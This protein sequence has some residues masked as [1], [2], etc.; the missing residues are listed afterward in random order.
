MKNRSRTRFHDRH[1]L[2]GLFERG[3]VQAEDVVRADANLR[4]RA[5]EREGRHGDSVG[6]GLRGVLRRGEHVVADNAVQGE[7]VPALHADSVEVG[8]S[9]RLDFLVLQKAVALHSPTVEPGLEDGQLGNERRVGGPRP[10][11]AF[12][13]AVVPLPRAVLVGDFGGGCESG[14]KKCRRRQNS[15]SD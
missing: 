12:P 15:R 3:R 6:G 2:V 8:E 14:H 1:A 4:L 13:R 10:C 11:A 9:Q 5:L 7:P